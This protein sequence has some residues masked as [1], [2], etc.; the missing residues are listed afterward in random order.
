M[1]Y[2]ETGLH[3]GANSVFE[4][5]LPHSLLALPEPAKGGPYFMRTG[6]HGFAVDR[7]LDVDFPNKPAGV[8]RIAMIGGGATQGW[9]VA[10]SD[11]DTKRLDRA[12]ESTLREKKAGIDVINLGMYQFLAYQGARALN[13]WGHALQPDVI[14]AYVGAE[15]LL[16]TQ[17]MRT[18]AWYGLYE[19]NQKMLSAQSA[20]DPHWF[21]RLRTMFPGL[22]NQTEIGQKIRVSLNS[23]RYYHIAQDR[24]VRSYGYEGLYSHLD[25]KEQEFEP[26]KDYP[27]ASRLEK[28]MPAGKARRY[29]YNADASVFGRLTVPFFIH[30]LKSIKR[31]FCGIPIVVVFQPIDWREFDVFMPREYATMQRQAQNE[32]AQYINGEWLFLNGQD[33][34]LRHLV[35]A[36][37]PLPAGIYLNGRGQEAMARWIAGQ[38]AQT[39]FLRHSASQGCS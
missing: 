32:L 12:L 1:L 10:K 39:P 36:D 6:D 21:W 19:Y 11:F 13:V 30:A 8:L 2:P 5:T 23:P 38:L 18:N 17:A 15:D 26:D 35:S 16:I 24:F 7:D 9:G 37:R 20:F 27:G 14:I 33:Y 25:A 3:L 34:W 4:G 22:L 29:R 28:T 31:D